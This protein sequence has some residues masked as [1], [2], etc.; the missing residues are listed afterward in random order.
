MTMLNPFRLT[1]G[2]LTAAMLAAAPAHAQ[3]IDGGSASKIAAPPHGTIETPADK[4]ARAVRNLAVDPK[5]F[6]AL[7]DAG[8]AS[9]LTGDLQAAAGFFGRA[10]ELNSN[11]P[12]PK[13]GMGAAAAL[14]NETRIA[15]QW[16]ERAKALGATPQHYGMD[17][18]LVYDLLG[19]G[20]EA[21]ADY[22]A[23]MAGDDPN[24]TRRRMALSMAING[25]MDGALKMLEPLLVKREP[26]AQRVRAFVLALG[27]LEKV[28]VSAIDQIQPGSGA[29]MAPF[30]S[31][32]RYLSADQKAAAVH[33][34]VFPTPA[35][36]RLAKA[37]AAAG[38]SGKTRR[39]KANALKVERK[40]IDPPT[41]N[42]SVSRTP[43]EGNDP[44]R[45]SASTSTVQ[46]VTL[47][48]VSGVTP[49]VASVAAN[50]VAP[51]PA[52]QP[53][54][55]PP[56]SPKPIIDEA[57][58]RQKA[59]Q[60]RRDAANRAEARR[61]A[62]A[63]E[64]ERKK[65]EAAARLGVPGTYWVQLAGGSNRN[66]LDEEF[67]RLKNKTSLLSGQSGYATEGVSFHRLLI[68]PFNTTGEANAMVNKLKAAG[69]DSF[70]WTRS[71]AQIKIERISG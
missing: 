49:P 40:P 48:P 32:L 57:A 38:S 1:L 28:A 43:I 13:I 42:M 64:A 7:I 26:Q 50:P 68:G 41:R 44:L 52:P 37:Q 20:D 36:V 47:P 24:E 12:F 34:G 54:I 11:S 6:F 63:A 70:R 10:E 31:D 35:E 27:G 51:P 8:R 46:R 23:A 69:I 9:L 39:A 61:K 56:P 19:Y 17:R 66:R 30:L 59:E 14:S 71:P 29:Q 58:E 65:K 2:C 4:L 25:D 60:A 67:R 15:M 3:Y 33:L 22:R 62:A 55:D 53:F 45:P 18:G 5:D 21:M 16:F